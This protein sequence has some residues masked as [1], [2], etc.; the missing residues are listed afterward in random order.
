[1]SFRLPNRR[2]RSNV[3]I[4]YELCLLWDELQNLQNDHLREENEKALGHIENCVTCIEFES[5]KSGL[6]MAVEYFGHNQRLGRQS[7]FHRLLKPEAG[8]ERQK[9]TDMREALGT[10]VSAWAVA[11]IVLFL[12]SIQMTATGVP[13]PHKGHI[14]FILFVGAV[15]GSGWLWFRHKG[16]KS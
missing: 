14:V 11:F 2:G 12:L 16:K 15:N 4:R 5:K 6:M 8:A 7:G 3:E 10:I 1:M 13:D 9:G